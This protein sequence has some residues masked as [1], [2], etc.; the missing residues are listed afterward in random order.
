M[1]YVHGYCV[2]YATRYNI[3]YF[4]T[5]PI[6]HKATSRKSFLKNKFR[7]EEFIGIGNLPEEHNYTYIYYCY[8][9]SIDSGR[10]IVKVDTN[11]S[12]TEAILTFSIR[13]R[14]V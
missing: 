4:G 14:C 13:F 8:N 10:R 5:L 1:L 11:A 12:L 9:T 7:Q 2:L 3:L 6:L